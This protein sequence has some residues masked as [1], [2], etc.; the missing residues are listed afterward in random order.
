MSEIK[1]PEQFTPNG[2]PAYAEPETFS[3][4]HGTAQHRAMVAFDI[5][6]FSRYNDP[7]VLQQMRQTLYQVVQDAVATTGLSWDECHYEDRGDG[8]Y[9]LAPARVSV[10]TLID[11]LAALIRAGLRRL[12]KTFHA[13]NQLRL[14]MAVHAG[15]VYRDEHGYVGADLNHLFRLLDAPEFRASFE[16][17]DLGL[18]A[19]NAV[20]Q[21]VISWGPGLIDPAEFQQISVVNKE[22]RCLAWVTPPTPQPPRDASAPTTP[23]RDHS[24]LGPLLVAALRGSHHYE[25]AHR[26]PVLS[27][28]LPE[29]RR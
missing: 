26:C 16:D 20:Y 10:Q 2:V 18:I 22:T 6:S 1:P 28:L 21:R 29:L 8:L 19:S 13:D 27:E 17:G 4:M 9:L 24:L 14:R 25:D 12:N 11:P 15:D 3:A 23:A 5:V 7:D